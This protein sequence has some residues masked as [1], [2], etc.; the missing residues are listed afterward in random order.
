M[1]E[2]PKIS[3]SDSIIP[4]YKMYENGKFH[5][6]VCPIRND[7]NSDLILTQLEQLGAEIQYQVH[8]PLDL[9]VNFYQ[10]RLPLLLSLQEDDGDY[11]ENTILQF[12]DLKNR[13]R[14]RIITGLTLC[15]TVVFTRYWLS[16]CFSEPE[17]SPLMLCCCRD[18]EQLEDDDDGDGKI[19]YV[20]QE[21]I[22]TDGKED[23]KKWLDKNYP[24]WQN[25]MSYWS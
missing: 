24:D 9:P 25:P 4:W 16:N 2:Y 11:S 18:L 6:C 14:L 21:R 5:Y 8:I 10:I 1:K 15:S 13:V 23:C 20:S 19:V 17:L 3:T 7:E 12:V 22:R